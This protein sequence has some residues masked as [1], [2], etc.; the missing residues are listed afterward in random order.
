VNVRFAIRRGKDFVGS[1]AAPAL[2]NV[3]ILTDLHPPV[4]G[5]YLGDIFVAFAAVDGWNSFPVRS[6]GRSVDAVHRHSLMAI[7][8]FQSIVHGLG[9][10]LQ[11][12]ARTVR[13]RL[14]VAVRTGRRQRLLVRREC[15]AR[16]SPHED[17]EE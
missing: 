13:S 6:L 1:V 11:L 14:V 2:G 5:V 4:L 8:A 3:R 12:G 17:R 7:S 15:V 16:E 9:E 10:D